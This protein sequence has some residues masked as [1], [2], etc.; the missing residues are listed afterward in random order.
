MGA[1]DF[2]KKFE[3]RVIDAKNYKLLKQNFEILEQQN[4]LL[5]DK[6]HFLESQMS[7]LEE[8]NIK[9]EEENRHL[10]EKIDRQS[11]KEEFKIRE[12][13]A[14]KRQQDGT[15]NETPYCPNCNIIMTNV[16]NIYSCPK[17]NYAKMSRKRANVL[18]RELNNSKE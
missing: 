9:L 17:C 14:F 8:H 18:A 5:K 2:L 16:A 15:F 7:K 6:V 1:L 13:I 3:G 12:G 4:Q 11:V 10:E